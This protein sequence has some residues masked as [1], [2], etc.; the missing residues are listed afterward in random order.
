MYTHYK[1]NQ[2][3]INW[4]IYRGVSKTK[5]DF[6]R[7]EVV[8]FI[9]N[10]RDKFFIPCSQ[11]QGT[12][13]LQIPE[14]VPAGTYSLLAIWTKNRERSLQRAI[15]DNVFTV[16]EFPAE[17]TLHGGA[18]SQPLKVKSS[19]GTFGY[20]GLSAYELA[21]LHGKTTKSEEQWIES[22]VETAEA[23]DQ[24]KATESQR[25]ADESQR[26]L[27]EISRQSAEE[28]RI[29]AEAARASTF[30]Q[31]QTQMAD[32]MKGN[33]KTIEQ[34][35]TSTESGGENIITVTRQDDTTQTFSIRNGQ[36]GATGA[37]GPQ[38][39]QGIQGPQ[40]NSGY[41]GA[42]GELEVVNNLTDGGAT[43]ALSAEQGV[44]VGTRL[45]TTYA[46]ITSL[47]D[48]LALASGDL[49]GE[50]KP[51]YYTYNVSGKVD[52]T[53]QNNPNY[54]CYTRNVSQF[55][56]M[57]LLVR[58]ISGATARIMF[59]DA[60]DTLI[61]NSESNTSTL[62]D[63]AVPEGAVTLK[64]SNDIRVVTDPYFQLDTIHPL[65]GKT[66]AVMG[67]SITSHYVS[68]VGDSLNSMLG[69]TL[70]G[71]FGV[72]NATASDYASNGEN[73]TIIAFDENPSSELAKNTLSNQ[74][75]RLMQKTTA[76]GEQITW[77]HP[78]DGTF[79]IDTAIGTG[80]GEA[81]APDIIY[82][83]FGINDAKSYTKYMNI[84]DEDIE[85]ILRQSYSSLTRINLV[86]AMRWALET[87]QCA[88]PLAQI[89][90][91]TPLQ[92]FQYLN[93]Q[94]TIERNWYGAKAGEWIKRVCYEV[95]ANIIDA[96]CE[97]GFTRLTAK[98]NGDGVHPN[99]TWRE[100]IA[101]YLANKIEQNYIY[102]S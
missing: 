70:I 77:T 30:S 88:Y 33:V 9:F 45:A 5:E 61:W 85:T 73:A 78:I 55:Q 60:E 76:E 99:T 79:T 53:W 3:Q 42:A 39:P 49:G 87:L 54:I 14:A 50:W 67:D 64:A 89:F 16:T 41:S 10:T 27:A 35:T 1:Q 13:T 18:P 59:F 97:S 90:V 95:G 8:T 98:N 26:S 19:A 66:I 72:G 68:K 36:Q 12:L 24:R 25:V 20:D 37:T 83:A 38:G 71:N 84:S 65:R 46:A 82:L 31:M 56:G 47:S 2:L 92:C 28:G 29:N 75:R 91:A 44:V 34:T 69:T 6:T 23:E 102:R 4:T 62:T 86:S 96:H 81:T 63:L 17:A 43:A 32:A 51:G 7:A 15:A 21:V 101:Q 52:G 94:Q 22:A 57:T 11:D 80:T 100:L 58:A 93:S 40:G 74:V 48:R